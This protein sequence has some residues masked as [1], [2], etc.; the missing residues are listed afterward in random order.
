MPSVTTTFRPDPTC[1]APS[2]LWVGEWYYG[3]S[4]YYPPFSPRPTEVVKLP[5]C[6]LTMLGCPGNGYGDDLCYQDNWVTT[7]NTIASNTAYSACPEGMTV[8]TNITLTYNGVT[9]EHTTCCPTAYDFVGP[10]DEPTTFPTVI[11]GTTYAMTYPTQSAYCK[12][13]SI[14][15]LSGQKVTLTVS[16]SR[17]ITTTEVEWDYEH[18]FLLVTPASIQKYLYTGRP[19]TTSTCFGGRDQH[20]V[21]SNPME[22]RPTS[23]PSG[24]YY[25]PPSTAVTQFTP[26]ASC[27]A[28]SNLWLC[29]HTVAGEP[30]YAR[31]ACY[32]DSSTVI[33][34][35][36]T[37]YTGC[38]VGYTTASATQYYPWIIGGQP[39]QRY[40]VEAHEVRCCPSAFGADHDITFTYT[41]PERTHTTIHDGTT[42]AVS[43]EFRL[44]FCV[45][46]TA[47]SQRGDKTVTLGLYGK[48]DARPGAPAKTYDGHSEAV[49]EAGAEMTLYAEAVG[50]SWTVFHGTH[51]CFDFKDCSQYFTYS[52][53][54]TMGPGVVVATPTPT[55]DGEGGGGGEGEAASSSSTAGAVAVRGDGRAGLAGVTVVVVVTVIVNTD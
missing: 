2:N 46:S 39:D 5:E 36:P 10:N 3:C 55:R 8:A 21:N 17:T 52:Y 34:N 9:L 25:P 54:N 41:L 14:E 33:N 45:A 22:P 11:D 6:R 40:S 20:C 26:A 38:P 35:T 12:A 42:H 29:T 50:L 19:G 43:R 16:A 30:D 53:N 51:T 28:E 13:A 32:P 24:T 47:A 1:F 23:A 44:P 31:V 48:K 18:D 49:W 7:G 4:T 15:N 37:Y 27:L